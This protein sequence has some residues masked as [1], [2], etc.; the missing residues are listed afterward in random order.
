[1]W[2]YDG[3]SDDD[4]DEEESLSQVISQGKRVMDFYKEFDDVLALRP[5]M[6]MPGIIQSSQ[7]N[8]EDSDESIEGVWDDESSENSSP[9]VNA[10]KRKAEPSTDDKS[11]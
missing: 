5:V 10:G 3:E 4:N 11:K 9:N 2:S 7:A 1:M 8:Q 6:T